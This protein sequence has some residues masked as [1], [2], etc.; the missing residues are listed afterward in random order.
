MTEICFEPGPSEQDARDALRAL[1]SRL[2]ADTPILALGGRHAVNAG[3]AVFASVAILRVFGAK[4]LAA[5]S[6]SIAGSASFR[7]SGGAEDAVAAAER[8]RQLA[9]SLP[10]DGPA[11]LERLRFGAE[12]RQT[13]TFLCRRLTVSGSPPL[14]LAAALDLPCASSDAPAPGAPSALHAGPAPAQRAGAE[15]FLWRTD[16]DDRLVEIGPQL[17]EAVGETPA[18]LMGQSLARII[19]SFDADQGMRL[20]LLLERQESFSGVEILWPIAGSLARASITLAGSARF[21]PQLRFLGFR[22]FGLI[23]KEP[24]PEAP[25]LDEPNVVPLHPSP[26]KAVE[27]EGLGGGPAGASTPEEQSAIFAVAASLSKAGQTA[28]NKDHE[29]IAQRFEQAPSSGSRAQ[30]ADLAR[31]LEAEWPGERGPAG[32]AQAAQSKISLDA[33]PAL[34]ALPIGVLICSDGAPSFAN[35]FL[36][37]LLGCADLGCAEAIGALAP[38]IKRAPGQGDSVDLRDGAGKAVPWRIRRQ[39]LGSQNLE[40]ISLQA[41]NEAPRAEAEL[42]HYQREARDLNA[43][44]DT[45]MDGVAVLDSQGRIKALNRSGEALFCYDKAEVAGEPFTALI[46]PESRERAAAYFQGLKSNGVAS[47]LNDGREVLGL[48]RQGGTIPIFMTLGRIGRA[49]SSAAAEQ[50]QRYCALLRDM[51]HWKKVERELD[52]ARREAER[53]SA[54]KSDFLAKV[55]HE[56]RTPLNAILGFAEVIMQERFGPIGSERYKGYLKDIHSSGALVMSLVNDLLDLSKIEAG[57]LELS[58]ESVDANHIVTQCVSMMQ[59]QASRARVITRLSL[60]PQLPHIFADERSLRQIVLNLLSNAIK[61]TRPGGQVIISTALTEA[62]CAALRIRD[63]GVGMSDD[64]LEVALEPFGQV[65]A[66]RLKGGTGLGLPLTKALVEANRAVFS[67]KS[68]P[69]EGTLVEVAFPPAR[70][71]SNRK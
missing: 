11:R 66:S 20:A 21:D 61:F 29:G 6:L 4:T 14:F 38:I 46:A 22:G 48:T 67:I 64:D 70:V 7:D 19:A 39:A 16:A 69:H 55:S 63:T 2:A 41:R 53:A 23:F 62:N 65:S 12:G 37:D 45:A 60:A 10:L 18:D 15:R 27:R 50:D 17:T 24:A 25:R 35:R 71:V 34:D 33:G 68:K 58:F 43:I 42:R 44:L 3:Q 47:L 26:D 1:S 40:L 56:I 59:P 54:L 51:S 8:L 52:E 9:S 49:G 30:L 5:L 32:A 13:M 57:K 28:Q 36:L 31:R